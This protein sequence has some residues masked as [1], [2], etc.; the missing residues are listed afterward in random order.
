MSYFL[1][2]VA[3]LSGQPGAGPLNACAQERIAL[4]EV[5]NETAC[6]LASRLRLTDWID[7]H[8]DRRVTDARCTM[9]EAAPISASVSSGALPSGA[10]R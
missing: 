8:G 10:L 2:V 4:P 5:H 6:Y 7:G 9:I 3:C 1:L